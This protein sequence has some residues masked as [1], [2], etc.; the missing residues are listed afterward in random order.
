MK[1]IKIIGSGSWL[2]QIRIS[3]RELMKMLGTGKAE[4]WVEQKLGI[5]NRALSISL[6]DGKPV[7][8]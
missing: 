4:I 6:P 1:N 2:P 8:T 7:N 5:V 3:S